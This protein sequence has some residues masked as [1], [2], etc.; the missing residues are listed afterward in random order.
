M[1]RSV[2]NNVA[3]VAEYDKAK[4][5]YD[6]FNGDEIPRVMVMNDDKPRETRVLDRGDY[7]SP[8]GDAL[9][10]APPANLPP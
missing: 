6:A 3:V 10:F 1:K 4:Q 9:A 7:L 5:A 8:I 2:T